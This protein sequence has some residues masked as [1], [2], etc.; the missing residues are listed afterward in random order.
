MSE[1]GYMMRVQAKDQIDQAKVKVDVETIRAVM[2]LMEIS[3]HDAQLKL[4][5]EQIQQLMT[6]AKDIKA[7]HCLQWQRVHQWPETH[8]E[9]IE[10][11]KGLSEVDFQRFQYCMDNYTPDY[12]M[13]PNILK[14][15][16]HYA[17]HMDAKLEK[18]YLCKDVGFKQFTLPP[19]KEKGKM[20]KVRLT[21][22]NQHMCPMWDMTP[23]FLSLI[24]D[25]L[26]QTA[27]VREDLGTFDPK[28]A[29][30]TRVE[31][32]SVRATSH[33]QHVKFEWDLWVNEQAEERLWGLSSGYKDD[34]LAK[35]PKHV[36]LAYMAAMSRFFGAF[37]VRN[38]MPYEVSEDGTVELYGTMAAYFCHTCAEMDLAVSF[39]HRRQH[40][41]DDEECIEDKQYSDFD[42][43]LPCVRPRGDA[44]V[45]DV[46][47]YTCGDV[48]ILKYGDNLMYEYLRHTVGFSEAQLRRVDFN[49][50]DGY[51]VCYGFGVK[52]EHGYLHSEEVRLQW[53]A[54]TRQ[55][56]KP[57][58][59]LIQRRAHARL[60]A[61]LTR[62]PYKSYVASSIKLRAACGP[63]YAEDVAKPGV[64][65][66]EVDDFVRDCHSVCVDHRMGDGRLVCRTHKVA[67]LPNDHE[68]LVREVRARTAA[69]MHWRTP[70]ELAVDVKVGLAHIKVHM[71]RLGSVCVKDDNDVC[72][73]S[74]DSEDD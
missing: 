59:T 28:N 9:F 38:A 41:H 54:G 53:E 58:K 35:Y 39:L 22:E 11:M 18:L 36:Q 34:S 48:S 31:I 60:G 44:D 49:A 74:S 6:A 50:L 73:C 70:Q 12:R 29:R 64:E 67:C 42:Y 14:T 4:S 30:H 43:T 17:T 57:E 10:R 68:D 46:L 61:E 62:L 40:K 69:L 33:Y 32:V 47:W 71:D 20:V 5:R 16:M 72:R 65:K 27:C 37:S 52:L 51:A 19:R 24:V 23:R 15:A 21:L 13:V 25:F 26:D 8:K 66:V 56:S 7:K 63:K 45:S 1:Q 3:L 55:L 2:D